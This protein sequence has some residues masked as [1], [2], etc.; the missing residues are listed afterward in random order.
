MEQQLV[1]AVTEA[2]EPTTQTILSLMV[3]EIR[4]MVEMV[5]KEAMAEMVELAQKLLIVITLKELEAQVVKVAKDILVENQE[6]VVKAQ[7][8]KLEVMALKDQQGLM[9][10]QAKKE[11]MHQDK[12]KNQH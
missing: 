2:K 6:K 5:A 11:K 9:V 4:A 12:L 7:M 1:E 3:M 8:V 10:W